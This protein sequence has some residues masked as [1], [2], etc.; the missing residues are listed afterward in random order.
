MSNYPA[1]VDPDGSIP[2]DPRDIIG[3]IED[4][5]RKFSTIKKKAK[6]LGPKFLAIT[7]DI[8][9]RVLP[10]GYETMVKAGKT[11]RLARQ[12]YTDQVGRIQRVE[13]AVENHKQELTRLI[14]ADDD[15]DQPTITIPHNI[16]SPT[17]VSEA[18]TI[19][20]LSNGSLDPLRMDAPSKQA[21][22]NKEYEN[23]KKLVDEKHHIIAERDDTIQKNERTIAGKQKT[24]DEKETTIRLRDGTISNRW[25]TI[26]PLNAI[27]ASGNVEKAQRDRTIQQLEEYCSSVEL[28]RD[29]GKPLAEETQ[30]ER[31]TI[32][33]QTDV[34][35]STQTFTISGLEEARVQLCKSLENT[36]DESFKFST[37]Y[38]AP[39][40]NHLASI[41]AHP[42]IYQV[43][44][45]PYSP[46]RF[47]LYTDTYEDVVVLSIVTTRPVALGLYGLVS[48]G[49]L[50]NHFKF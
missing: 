3:L 46:W 42:T 28:E 16:P 17:I 38:P 32:L 8:S 9:S 48:S 44:D 36:I 2:D 23:A 45:T 13:A 26:K 11:V 22:F 41:L 47:D 4:H 21:L 50:R 7:N 12:H 25:T 34:T 27:I 14:A 30:R 15:G 6:D 24:I 1:A 10:A 39:S 5:K 18:M 49:V 20:L 31:D 29:H 40:F 37:I 35:I 33:A 19:L 43:S